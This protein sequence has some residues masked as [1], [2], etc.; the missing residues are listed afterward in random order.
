MKR[1]LSW[2]SISGTTLLAV[3]AIYIFFVPITSDAIFGLYNRLKQDVVVGLRIKELSPDDLIKG[4]VPQ[5]QLDHYQQLG[6]PP[7]LISLDYIY[8]P[9]D[10]VLSGLEYCFKEM[11]VRSQY[12]KDKVVQSKIFDTIKPVC[13]GQGQDQELKHGTNRILSRENRTE[14]NEIIDSFIYNNYVDHFW[15]PFDFHTINLSID[16]KGTFTNKDDIE[17]DY[18]KPIIRVTSVPPH[19]LAIVR[20]NRSSNTYNIV[21]MRLPIYIALTILVPY[22]VT[23]IL[24]I[25]RK[26]VRQHGSFWEVTVAM[27]FGLSGLS[28]LFVPDYINYPTLASSLL[29]FLYL[30][31]TIFIIVTVRNSLQNPPPDTA[32]KKTTSPNKTNKK[33]IKA[34]NID[35]LDSNETE[36]PKNNHPS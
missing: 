20:F 11:T 23:R 7:V 30:L 24:M 25:L 34:I 28:S 10:V 5:W 13:V 27:V 4:N 32:I 29:L 35:K 31:I 1:T 15:Y 21:L 14:E 9:Q 22:A 17:S 26:V 19:W 16:I 33:R 8:I 36:L 3:F 6:I 18:I 2:L 12:S